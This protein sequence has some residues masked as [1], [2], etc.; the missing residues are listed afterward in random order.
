MTISCPH[1]RTEYDAEESEYGRFVKCEICGK[2]FVVGTS[3]FDKIRSSTLP[4]KVNAVTKGK[5]YEKQ[6]RTQLEDRKSISCATRLSYGSLW[7]SL[8]SLKWIWPCLLVIGFTVKVHNQNHRAKGDRRAR[9]SAICPICWCSKPSENGN[10]EIPTSQ[11]NQRGGRQ[12]DYVS[13]NENTNALTETKSETISKVSVKPLRDSG[14]SSARNDLSFKTNTVVSKPQSRRWRS[15]TVSTNLAT[16]GMAAE[17]TVNRKEPQN[18]SNTNGSQEVTQAD[19]VKNE[20]T[21][22]NSSSTAPNGIDPHNPQFGFGIPYE[23][24]VKIQDEAIAKEKQDKAKTLSSFCGVFLGAKLND[25]SCP[26]SF[27]GKIQ[28]PWGASECVNYWNSMRIAYVQYTPETHKIARIR[29]KPIDNGMGYD[30][31]GGD[32]RPNKFLQE[33]LDGLSKKYKTRPYFLLSCSKYSLHE[34][35]GEY[36]F[37]LGDTSVHI[38]VSTEDS[39]FKYFECVHDKYLELG[40]TETE[41][42]IAKRKDDRFKLFSKGDFSKGDFWGVVLGKVYTTSNYDPYDDDGSGYIKFGLDIGQEWPNW[43]SPFGGGLTLECFATCISKRL[44]KMVAHSM[45]GYDSVK[46]AFFGLCEMTSRILDTKVTWNNPY[47]ETYTADVKKGDIEINI[48]RQRN[49]LTFTVV[50]KGMERLARQELRQWERN[51]D[52]ETKSSIRQRVDSL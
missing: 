47:S 8:L 27:G 51:K 1:C 15:S 6:P 19:F 37:P 24:L 38:Y 41:R 14:D 49:A 46:D 40:K 21:V 23:K 5:H 20:V 30:D 34:A 36:M 13:L 50:H 29:L 31:Y 43:G 32:V 11:E 2:G 44:A 35:R 18:T 26:C 3:S 7:K 4:H 16:R 52:E 22:S 25:T 42:L 33:F 39:F 12:P 45:W 48:Y 28:L 9:P 17:D 10:V